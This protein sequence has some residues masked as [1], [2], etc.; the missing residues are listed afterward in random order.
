[1]G[2][3]LAKKKQMRNGLPKGD[4]HGGKEEEMDVRVSLRQESN[5]PPHQ[6]E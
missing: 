2:E 6:P 4:V 5:C 3:K 1:M